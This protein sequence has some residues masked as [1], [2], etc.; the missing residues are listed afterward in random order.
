MPGS[1]MDT[2]LQGFLRAFASLLAFQTTM[3]LMQSA[4]ERIGM[5]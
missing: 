4:G 3:R 2:G 5:P 1:R